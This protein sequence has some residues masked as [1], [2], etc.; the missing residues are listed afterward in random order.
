MALSHSD[1]RRIVGQAIRELKFECSP[2][3]EELA[4]VMAQIETDY[5]ASERPVSATKDG[6]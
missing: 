6:E 4:D 3:A 1:I 2:T 5:L